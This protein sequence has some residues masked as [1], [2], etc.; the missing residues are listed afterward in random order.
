[1]THDLPRLGVEPPLSNLAVGSPPCTL[2]TMDLL[3]TLSEERCTDKARPAQAVLPAHTALDSI[4]DCAVSWIDGN[5]NIFKMFS[6][7]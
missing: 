7:R 5:V 4:R 2:V 1:M 6:F 3:V